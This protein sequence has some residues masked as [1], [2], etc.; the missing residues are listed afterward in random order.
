[1]KTLLLLFATVTILTCLSGSELP[2]VSKADQQH[3]IEFTGG[4]RFDGKQFVPGTFYVVNGTLTFRR[5]EHVDR[6]VDLTGKYL[7][8]PFGE[9]HNHNLVWTGEAVLA[10]LKRMYLEGGIFYV[11]NPTNLPSAVAG[12]AGKINIP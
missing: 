5:P 3:T 2:P 10:R 12:L 8:P 9:A 7:I 1:M 4:R 11:K 6:V